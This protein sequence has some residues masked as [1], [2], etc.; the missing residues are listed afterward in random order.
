MF[1]INEIK[2]SLKLIQSSGIPLNISNFSC[3]E[4]GYCYWEIW[5]IRSVLT[6][7]KNPFFSFFVRM[8]DS[9]KIFY[10][11]YIKICFKIIKNKLYTI[12]LN[13][14]MPTMICFIFSSFCIYLLCVLYV[15]IY[16]IVSYR[17]LNIMSSLEKFFKFC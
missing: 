2:V 13:N 16:N 6:I 17:F 7:K 1:L 15:F 5:G 10:G 9:Y 3:N 4:S 14:F 11:D 12:I 8:C